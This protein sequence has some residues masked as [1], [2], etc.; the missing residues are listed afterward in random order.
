MENRLINEESPYLKQ[1]ANNPVNW[2]PWS[3]EAFEIAKKE[4]KLIFVSIGYSS[5]HWCHVMQKE[6][7][8]DEECAKVLNE[9][10][11][12]IK[13]DKEERPDIDKHFQ[14]IYRTM[15]KKPGGWPLSIFITPNKEPI[16]SATYIPPI[17]NY[18][19]MGF[20]E[21]LN[22][23]AK[24]WREN[25]QALIKK[26]QEII[27]EMKPKTKIEATKITPQLEEIVSK[28]IKQLY[29]KSY[30][31]FGKAPK[32][33]QAS[34][35]MLI[36][37]LY[38]L[39]KDEEL[40]DILIHTLD[41]MS[42]GGI[43]DIVDGGFCRYSTD[44]IWLVPHF[45]KMTYDNAL[46]IEVYVE[47]Y[48][49]TNIKK[50]KDIAIEI[51]EFMLN[52]M[53]ENMLFFSSSDADS[54]GVEGG[55]FI[56]DY[57]EVKE[58]F[59]KENIDNSMLYNLS[60]TKNG[61]FDGKSIARFTDNK[62][63]DL[64]ETKK[65]INILKKI[66]KSREYPS[67][68]NKIITSWNSMMISSLYKLSQ[69]EPNYLD[70]ANDALDALKSK[71]VNGVDI[72]HSALIDTKPKI[73]G[74]LEDYAY[75]IEALLAKYHITL[76]ETL[77]IEATN[78]TN[79]AI[80]RF[81]L[82]G[83]WKVGN[84]EFKDFLDD[85]DI[86]YPSPLSIMVKN[87]LTLRSLVENIY[88]KFAFMTLQVESYDLMRQPIS[89]PT[90]TNQAIRYLRDDNIIKSDINILQKIS[91]KYINYPYTLFKPTT[92]NSI[93]ICNNKACFARFNSIDEFYNMSF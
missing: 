21:L 66:R 58:A 64:E 61:N 63:R 38:R 86:S 26:A 4:N 55:Y 20:K 77:L 75:Y 22:L 62:I 45:E 30:G 68:D 24:N 92:S 27:Q 89:R 6:S 52:N 9:N 69:I 8:E 7:F 51:A 31:G 16:Y 23:L 50:Y 60:I 2:Y 5:C 80:K 10:F 39:N 54:N 72:F 47:A 13:V 87:L 46:M 79:E 81:Y 93:E 59:E 1:H 88:E 84:G 65:A 67:I 40:K 12:S 43:Y 71:M 44:E 18:G 36:I 28:Q 25:P 91:K 14:E 11:I 34:T 78:I 70:I 56:Y 49:L 3:N 48:R 33:P 41:M 19:L 76:D 35:L 83:R 17:S 57:D 73:E 85:Y 53:N 82:N 29:D 37:N 32:F 90:L 15:N 42:L 74:F